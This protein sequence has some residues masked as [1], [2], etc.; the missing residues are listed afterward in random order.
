ME[1]VSLTR[2]R[3]GAR[4]KGPWEVLASSGFKRILGAEFVPSV[5]VTTSL[6]SG[7]AGDDAWGVGAAG[8]RSS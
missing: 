5:M 2:F 4:Q 3:V 1:C 8:G 7:F 6:L